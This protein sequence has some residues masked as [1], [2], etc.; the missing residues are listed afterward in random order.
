MTVRAWCRA[1]RGMIL[2][3]RLVTGC[4]WRLLHVMAT[5]ACQ[6]KV[7]RQ[8]RTPRTNDHRPCPQPLHHD[9][10]S[11]NPCLPKCTLRDAMPDLIVALGACTASS[12]QF[13]AEGRR[14]PWNINALMTAEATAR[15]DVRRNPSGKLVV[16]TEMGDDLLQR[17]ELVSEPRDDPLID[18]TV[19][20]RG[21]RMRAFRPRIVVRDHLV[22]RPAERR[23]VGVDGDG[24]RGGQHSDRKHGKQDPGSALRHD[25]F[26]R[27]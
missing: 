3:R 8:I 2:S 16:A 13:V 23:T 14:L 4:T 19:D 24:E 18:M 26:H 1:D 5:G 17:D 9:A 7:P 6:S 22:T 15:R 25:A 27:W 11:Q 21:L 12:V 10:L 20:T